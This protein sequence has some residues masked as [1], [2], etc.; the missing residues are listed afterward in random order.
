MKKKPLEYALYL[1]ELRDRSVK[2]IER[3]MTE[4][5]YT[6]D[7][8]E[9]SINFLLDKDFLNDERFVENKIKQLKLRGQGK[10][11][12]KFSLGRYGLAK[13]LI[14]E[15][16]NDISETEEF[17]NAKELAQKLIKKKKIEPEKR[18]EKVGRFLAGRGYSIEVVKKVLDKLLKNS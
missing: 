6:A 13:E 14:D 7:D 15:K 9:K 4:K 8:I 17:E 1:L 2:E 16:V 10:F 18:Y 11:K 5:E 3:K 12:V